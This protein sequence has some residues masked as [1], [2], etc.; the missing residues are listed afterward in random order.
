MVDQVEAS[1]GEDTP[2]SDS[3]AIEDDAANAA[4]SSGRQD[5]AQ[6]V[7]AHAISTELGD[8]SEPI[9]NEADP[10]QDTS[11][12][13]TP[14][15]LQDGAQGVAAHAIS[16]E[17]G[18]QSGPISNEADAATMPGVSSPLEE[19]SPAADQSAAPQDHD[20]AS[21]PNTPAGGDANTGNPAGAAAEPSAMP[22]APA[23]DPRAATMSDARHKHSSASQWQRGCT[24]SR[25]TST[26][27]APLPSHLSLSMRATYILVRPMSAMATFAH[28][29]A[30][31]SAQQMLKQL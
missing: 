24:F 13:F 8:Q 10:A 31:F 25:E 14:S 16:I 20:A 27:S 26:H 23:A 9:S 6:D 29:S 5:G 3:V 7:A 2:Q 4:N 19:H 11:A 18:D 21:A 22:H 17:L 15:D 12:G 28:S 30:P 1:Q